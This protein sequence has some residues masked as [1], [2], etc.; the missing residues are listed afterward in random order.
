MPRSRAPRQEPRRQWSAAGLEPTA[1]QSLQTE[2]QPHRCS[3]LI[4]HLATESSSSDEIN[5]FCGFLLL[6]KPYGRSPCSDF[7]VLIQPDMTTRLLW[8]Q[9]VLESV[10]RCASQTLCSCCVNGARAP[11]ARSCSSDRYNCRIM[12]LLFPAVQILGHHHNP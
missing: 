3:T 2:L 11:P 4:S 8:P 6:W 9:A 7:S 5:S 12:T 10:N 1:L